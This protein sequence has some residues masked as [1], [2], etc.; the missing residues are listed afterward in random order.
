[1]TPALRPTGECHICGVVGPLSFEHTP[2]RGAFNNRTVV[3]ATF[4][5]VVSLGP[6]GTA[7]GTIEQ[8]GMGAFTLCN[9]CNNDTG[10]WYGNQ[11]IA[12]CYQGMQILLASGGRPSLVYPHY[13]FPLPTIKQVITMFFIVNQ[14]GFAARNPE[15]VA[16]VLN[17]HRKYLD[18]RYRIFIYYNIEG[19]YRSTGIVGK[20]SLGSGSPPIILS[21]MN[22]PPFGYVMTYNGTVP[23][24]QLAEIAHFAGYDYEEFKILNI[25]LPVLPTHIWIPTDYRTKEQI[26]ADYQENIRK[27]PNLRKSMGS[28]GKGNA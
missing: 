4:D 26:D 3:A 20:V 19:N 15:L 2:P 28:T 16:F 23:E 9:K 8:K 10:S 17:K 21:E 13:L 25:R 5:Q 11:F 7:K 27:Y 14:L 1:M 24:K 22:F 6:E 18:P 12:W